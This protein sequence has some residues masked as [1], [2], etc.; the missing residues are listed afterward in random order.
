MENG[1]L[2]FG[3]QRLWLLQQLDP[4]S[5][6]YNLP[7]AL[8]F[9]GGSD[10]VAL[11]RALDRLV[12]RHPIFRTAYVADGAGTPRAVRHSGFSIPVDLPKDDR[13]SWED[14][15]A[16]AVARP[17]DLAAAPPV[18][19][20]LIDDADGDQV[21]CL[22]MHH[23]MADGWSLRVLQRD[24]VAFYEGTEL[25]E[26]TV[27]YD[28]FVA[29]QDEHVRQDVIAAQLDYWRAELAGFEP[30]ELP[31]D[32][33]RP[34]EPSAAGDHV[35][36]ALSVELT[37]ALRTFALRQRSVFPSV[38]AALFQ[39][40]LAA[41]S[42]SEDVTIGSV[43]NGREQ[44]RF[45]DVVGFFVNT[46][47]LRSTL[48]S[49][50][51]FR[52]LV[53][54]V[55]AKAS[56]A[57][58]RQDVPF[59]QVVAAVQPE[60]EHGR[61]AIF[62]VVLV[63]HGELES[64]GE[65]VGGRGISRVRW[66]SP[67][68]RFD[69]E[70]RSSVVDD[71]LT[72]I[73]TYRSDL[74]RRSTVEAMA[75]R[76]VR[77]AEEVMASP[78]LPLSRVSLLGEAERGLLATW[79]DTAVDVPRVTLVELLEDQLRRSPAAEAVV[80]GEERL[81]YQELHTRADQL[82][83]ALVEQGAGP[84]RVVA[85]ALPRS[86][87]LVVALLAVLKSG[88][89]Y[90]PVD[91]GL[92]AERVSF[93]LDE[94]QPVLVIDSPSTVDDLAK[95]TPVRP[96]PGNAAYVIYT[97]GSTGRPKGVVV[98]HDAIVNRLLWMQHEFGL[99]ASD[100][101][102]QKTP[103]GF[104]VSVWEFFWPLISGATLVVAA[105]GGHRDPSYLVS[106]IRAEKI[107]T[108]HFVP[109]MLQ[110]FLGDTG[111]GSCTG[112][113]RVICSG[114]ALT[115]ALQE[116]FL[117]T[118]PDVGLFNLYGP[119]EA[120]V[121]VTSWDCDGSVVGGVVP[122]GRPV[123]N[124]TAHVLDS[125]LRPVG[126]G[127]PGELY[128][129]G[130]QIA[131]GYAGRTG[132]T[133]ERFVADPFG[134]GERMY[135]TG[136]IAQWS[137]DGA[138]LYLGR[139]DDQV[140]LRGM[141]IEPGEISSTLLRHPGL[142]DAAVVV[143]DERLVA[144]V[145][146]DR[147]TAGPVLEL[148]RIDRTGEASDLPRHRLP[149][150]M[151]VIGRSRAEVDFLYQEIFLDREYLRH[152]ISIPSGAVVF[153]VGAHVGLFSLFAARQ[154]TDVTVFAF[155]PIPDLHRELS[156]NTRVNGVDT[157]LF[158]CGLASTSGEATFTYYPQAS[159]L[160]GRYSEEST[161]REVVRAYAHQSL[162]PEEDL[163]S[164]IDD[165]V[166]ERLQDHREVTC[167]LRTIS[168]VIDE[169]GV[170][171]IDLLKVDAEKSEW[172]V[173]SGIRPEHWPRIRQVVVEVHDIDTRVQQVMNLLPQH[174]FRVI[175]DRAD[176][177]GN[178]DLVNLF[179]VRAEHPQAPPPSRTDWCNAADLEADVRATAQAS[180][181]DYLRPVDYVVLDALPLSRNGKLDRRALP[182]P[183]RPVSETTVAPRTPREQVLCELFAQVLGVDRV[184][185]D[186]GFFDLG[187]HSLLAA[188]LVNA[189]QTAL[190]LELSVG[191]IFQAPTVASLSALLA[192]DDEHDA[193]DVLLPIRAHGEGAPVFFVHP[194]IG[195]SWCY[196]GFSKHLPGIPMFGLQARAIND[197]E[198]TV[199]DLAD[200]ARDYV[201][202]VRRIQPHG[203]YRLA[204]WSFGG[205]AAHTMVAQLQD[206][207]ERVELLALLDAYPYAG[208]PSTRN[209]STAQ[210]R[211]ELL[212]N[213]ALRE[214]DDE[215]AERIIEVHAAITRLPVR[216]SPPVYRGDA[217]LF[218]ARGHERSPEQW[219]EF[220]TGEIRV[221]DVPSSHD[222]LLAPEPL[223][224]IAEVLAIELEGDSGA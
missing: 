193:M 183:D 209:R 172:E 77:L 175:A 48:D 35:D 26:L 2:S 166:T 20:M 97:S 31:L 220:I 218:Q 46:V 89:A 92:P 85:V 73:L 132:L 192:G 103:V 51:S 30:L 144:Y 191:T 155:E 29:W 107:T 109:S 170:D 162:D 91:E 211:H 149:N 150:G 195:L 10:P 168:D 11:R 33:P 128:L 68:T 158:H 79:N 28:D 60:R 56:A 146:P 52:D 25:P 147:E 7:L 217:V 70:L 63:H 131:R 138:L 187:G 45:D 37:S 14:H 54:A 66:L 12:E 174:G 43:L 215:R 221:H 106:L 82:A 156:L 154:T 153:D 40:L 115:P 213:G 182:A 18:R 53:R 22:V 219:R 216:F 203:P 210:F 8:H 47:T 112:L 80:F 194:G 55:H 184:G 102:L 135:R 169:H 32:H 113:R 36:F 208:N 141:R 74:L 23:I 176:A 100:R 101:V 124:T 111:A 214:I 206:L 86:V 41:Q 71:R 139:T 171:R 125:G 199:R 93:V 104:D 137:P 39:A 57:H 17:F 190:G 222:D 61:N 130:V 205:N 83:G 76:F 1:S 204:G 212:G 123:W 59:D 78:D 133:A 129:G 197:P 207:G 65:Q 72:G 165:L 24:L 64:S 157:R 127:V 224:E 114:E 143:H 84:D 81:T 117:R 4:T 198:H 120:A 49:S 62:D 108:T 34:A 99:D 19:G 161:E 118:L 140:K 136:D 98:S 58:E 160:S 134:D 179:A 6:A 122:I 145:V 96:S 42:G 110:I 181:P 167:T 148:A 188:R 178:S 126:T 177:L 16:E 185:V 5:A 164:L 180:L 189:V 142:A 15:A 173:L 163:D 186:D 119:T 201:T 202:E 223:A 87:E 121:D 50:T 200:L 27:R 88:A 69:L 38:V 152:G 13:R 9:P 116:Q 159:I 67:S 196:A 3:Q 151:T 21:L 95:S 75:E 90:L 94:T 44:S 105:P